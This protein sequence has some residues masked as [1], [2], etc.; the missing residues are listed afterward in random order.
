M[1]EA[2]EQVLDHA[3]RSLGLHRIEANIQPGNAPSIALARGAGFRLEGF[4]P[5]YLLI[6]GQWRDH[7]RYAIT[8]DEHAAARAAASSA[9]ALPSAC[10]RSAQRSSTSSQPTLMRIRPSGMCSWPGWALRRSIVVSTPPRLVACQMI[11]VAA[12]ARSTVASSASSKL[13]TAPKPG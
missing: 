10:S 7:E 12:Q 11:L 4:S 2:L 5:R 9:E 3:F 6:G 1:G 13:T 8:V